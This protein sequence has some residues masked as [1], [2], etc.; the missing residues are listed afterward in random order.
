MSDKNIQ[1]GAYG[2]LHP[3]WERSFYPDD[4]PAE[5]FLSYYSNEFN[6]VMVPAD[7]WIKDEGF[8]C[9]EWLDDIHDD[10]RFYIEC[11]IQALSDDGAFTL[12]LK[13]LEFLQAHLAGVY[14]IDSLIISMHEQGHV[15][16]LQRM[17]QQTCLFCDTTISE[18]EVTP[19]WRVDAAKNKVSTQL[20]IF[21]DNLTQ[22]RRTRVNV[23]AFAE[24]SLSEQQD[25]I[26]KHKTLSSFDLMR[27]RSV[28]E[29]MGL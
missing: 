26:V 20:A 4:M 21:E 19:V 16:Q 10:F 1:V 27:F 23:E 2:W 24:N 9:E 15:A 7:Y 28:I 14:L 8:N 12:F 11:P 29:I 18:L 5:W 17:A 6:T 3:H 25:I 13:Q 22:L